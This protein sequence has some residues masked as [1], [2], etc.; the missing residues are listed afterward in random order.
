MREGYILPPVKY[1]YTGSD[2]WVPAGGYGAG[3][4]PVTALT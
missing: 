1:Y 3:G 4:A 2:A